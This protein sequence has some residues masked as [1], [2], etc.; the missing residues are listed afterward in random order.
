MAET[1]G[2]RLES[3]VLHD[4]HDLAAFK[5]CCQQLG[6]L[7]PPVTISNFDV[8]Q[9]TIPATKRPPAGIFSLLDV[10]RCTDKKMTPVVMN[11]VI[12]GVSQHMFEAMQG[13]LI[14]FGIVH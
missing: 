9:H 11:R 6:I 13:S 5:R 12:D 1:H 3:Y 14:A 2:L 10:L 4:H 8:S 7:L